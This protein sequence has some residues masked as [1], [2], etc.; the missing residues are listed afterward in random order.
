MYLIFIYEIVYLGIT[1]VNAT[2]ASGVTNITK[3]LGGNFL[4]I[5][6]LDGSMYIST[7][8]IIYII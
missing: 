4:E 2:E 5:V 1:T 3:A 7:L 8:D 6:S